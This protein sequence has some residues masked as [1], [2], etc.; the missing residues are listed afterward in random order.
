MGAFQNR[1]SQICLQ[2][3]DTVCKVK[4]HKLYIYSFKHYQ[5]WTHLENS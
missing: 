3:N 5:K 2:E 4:L 1:F